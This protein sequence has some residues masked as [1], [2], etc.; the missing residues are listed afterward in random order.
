LPRTSEDSDENED[1]LVFWES[2]K[3]EIE[4]EE[5]VGCEGVCGVGLGGGEWIELV[6]EYAE[7]GLEGE[8]L[9][10]CEFTLAG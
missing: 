4:L 2:G 5:Q 10:N 6:Q 1:M 9:N 3:D 8:E 7:G